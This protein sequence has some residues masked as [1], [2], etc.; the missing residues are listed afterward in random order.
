MSRID[1]FTSAKRVAVLQQEAS[2]TQWTYRRG[3]FPPKNDEVWLLC[4]VEMKK[5]KRSRVIGGGQV[6]SLCYNAGEV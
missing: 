2:P 1:P 6:D 4:A 3:V 5:E